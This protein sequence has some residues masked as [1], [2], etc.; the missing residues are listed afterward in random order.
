VARSREQNAMRVW[1][2]GEHKMDELAAFIL[3]P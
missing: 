1:R 2:I 3:C